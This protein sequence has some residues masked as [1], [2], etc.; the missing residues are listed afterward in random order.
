LRPSRPT[1]TLSL[2]RR[3]SRLRSENAFAALGYDTVYLMADAVKRANGT[4]SAAVKK[5]LEELDRIHKAP[6]VIT[7]EDKV[8]IIQDWDGRVYTNGGATN[9]LRFKLR[10]GDTVDRD[11]AM[12]LP[13]QVYYRPR[14]PEPMFR[15]RIRAQAGILVPQMVQSVGGDKQR[16]WDAGIGWDFFHLGPVNAALYTGVNSAGGGLGFDLT[17]N[18][19]TYAGYSLVYDGLKSSVLTGVY[20]SFN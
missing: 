4:D 14:P 19:G 6:A 15:L 11:F 13:T 16:F 1:P 7:T 9:P 3:S 10:V 18:F 20:F 17:K 8:V 12:T 5:A 2:P